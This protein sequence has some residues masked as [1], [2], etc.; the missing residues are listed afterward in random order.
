MNG[1]PP[2]VMKLPAT[3]Q[4]QHILLETDARKINAEIE[5]LP[6]A[7]A[8]TALTMAYRRLYTLNRFSMPPA[9]RFKAAQPFHNA[10][11]RF[12]AHYRSRISG[13][14]HAQDTDRNELDLLLNFMLE[15]G[16][17]YKHLIQDTLYAGKNHGRQ[18]NGIASVIYM[19]VLYSYYYSLFS[20]NRGR[21]LGPGHWVEFH[22]LYALAC[23]TGTENDTVPDPHTHS[24]TVENVYKKALLLGISSPYTRAA[25]EQWHSADYL[26]RHARLVSLYPPPDAHFLQEAYSV[27]PECTSSAFIPGSQFQVHPQTKLLDNGRLL[28]TLHKQIQGLKRGEPLRTAGLKNVQRDQAVQLLTTLFDTWSRSSTRRDE[29]RVSNEQI[30]LVWGLDNICIM[31]DPD[32]RRMA[33]IRNSGAGTDRRAWSVA[34]DE[35]PNGFCVRIKEG[36]PSYPET[37]QIVALIREHQGRKS[38]EMGMVKWAAISRDDIARCGIERLRGNAKK[39]SLRS[40]DE[41]ISERNGLLIL[42]KLTSKTLERQVVVPN[43]A[44]KPQNTVSLL[45]SGESHCSDFKVDSLILKTRNV[46]VFKVEL[47]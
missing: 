13:R 9:K 4:T 24:S 40:N 38:L 31:L 34:N 41:L 27:S 16:Y 46:D 14:F 22:W 15:L 23:D 25:D 39:V 26:E 37:G 17:A 44:I 20:Y 8:A 21:L 36:S 43:G 29:R 33:A 45:P 11:V 3:E 30:G 35:S 42:R 6:Y 18:I 28:D 5:H 1:V 2:L 47:L 7:D 10:F 19:A 12:V 32:Q